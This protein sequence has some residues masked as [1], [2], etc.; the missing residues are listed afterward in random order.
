M[1]RA[2]VIQP[3]VINIDGHNPDINQILRDLNR[4]TH[5]EDPFNDVMIARGGMAAFIANGKAFNANNGHVY[6]AMREYTTDKP[7]AIEP[8][9]A[10][11]INFAPNAP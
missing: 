10:N 3:G 8:V 11:S 7:V 4:T 9:F 6:E 1:P 2:V 5:K